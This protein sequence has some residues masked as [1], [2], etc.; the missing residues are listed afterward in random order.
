[1]S[2]IIEITK[3][4]EDAGNVWRSAL[5]VLRVEGSGT[6]YKFHIFPRRYVDYLGNKCTTRAANAV[7]VSP[8]NELMMNV[9]ETTRYSYYCSPDVFLLFLE[10][11]GTHTNDVKDALH[12][13]GWIKKVAYE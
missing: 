10:N 9:Q 13:M 1:M 8:T 5:C 12:H 4:P 11:I 6:L 7:L 3:P 2:I